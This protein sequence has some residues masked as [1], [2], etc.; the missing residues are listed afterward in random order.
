MVGGRIMKRILVSAIATAVLAGVGGASAADMPV[1]A[2]PAPVVVDPWTGF[3]VGLNGGYSWGRSDTNAAFYNAT[4]GAVIVPP[5]GSVITSALNLN[6]GVF[7]AQAGYNRLN[8]YFLWGIET[9]IQWSGEKGSATFFCA[10]PTTG[11]TGAPC[12]QQTARTFP[13]GTPIDALSIQQQI[14][15]FG[16]LRGRIG[17]LATPSWLLYVTGGLAYGEI[18]TASA[19]TGLNGNGVASTVAASLTTT[20]AGWTVGLGVEGRINDN[21]SAKAEYLYVDLGTVNTV[22]V[23]TAT[24]PPLLAASS[25][26]VTDNI[27]RVGINYRFH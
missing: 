8:G 20:R 25:S 6:G 1:K 3:Y 26:K 9:D 5:A 27:F 17:T 15:W 2:P 22:I 18:K 19:L 21:W 4:T 14:D 11:T 10:N 13:A 16:T 12:T 7:G 23:N 24:A